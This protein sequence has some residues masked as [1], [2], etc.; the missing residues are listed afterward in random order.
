MKVNIVISIIGR[1]YRMLSA[2]HRVQMI[3]LIIF[4]IG[5]SLVETLGISAI[6]PFISL[7]SNPELLDAGIY[8]QVYRFLGFQHKERFLLFFGIAIIVFYVF[9]AFYSVIHTYLNNRYSMAITKVFSK[10]ILNILLSIQYKL[11]VQKNSGNFIAVI[12]NESRNL[13]N[14]F[15]QI[16]QMST[17]L[18]TIL[19]I[20]IVLIAVNWQMTLILTGILIVMVFIFLQFLVSKNKILGSKTVESNRKTVRILVETFGNYKY[21]KLKGNKNEI[22]KNF[23]K[24]IHEYAKSHVTSL[25]LNALPKS[26]LES[27]GFSILIGIIIFII[28]RYN[29]AAM[30]IPVISMYALALYRILPS[31]H[32]LI[33]N[34][35]NIAFKHRSLDLVAENLNM[36][37]ETDSAE[38]IDFNSTIC[39]KNISFNYASGGEVLSNI[40][41]NINKGEKIAFTGESGGGKSTLIDL[42]IGIHRPVAGDIL[43]DNIPLSDKN[44]HSWR[45]RI[46]YIPQNIYLFDGTVADNVS[47]GSEKNEEKLITALK[48]ANIWDFLQTKEGLNTKVGEGGIQLSGGQQQRI[49]IARALYDDPEIIVLDEATSSLDNDTEQ[50]IMDEIYTAST[51]KTLIIIAHRLSTVDR[52]DRK[53]LIENGRIVS[54]GRHTVEKDL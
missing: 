18:F 38:Y 5:F 28:M 37:V 21:I 4:S 41:L 1:L 7:T 2:K 45:K 30:V 26:I 27:F 20:Y 14:L 35:N 43:I 48:K 13:G 50:K 29:N 54:N 42:I 47:F 6:M 34:I 3:L 25:T 51:Y 24:A 9:R 16:L 8:N 49:G 11:F 19:L 39:I 52:C 17:E 36:P 40:N 31:I 15:V 32:R 33:G 23:E 22:I 10:K 12:N 44:I 53:V 46:G